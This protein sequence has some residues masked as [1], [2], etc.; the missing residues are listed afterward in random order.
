MSETSLPVRHLFSIT[1][2]TAG[3]PVIASDTPQGSRML[4][5]VDGGAAILVS[6]HGIGLVEDG[7]SKAR[8]APLFETGDERYAWLNNIQ[9]V[10]VGGPSGTSVVNEIYEL[11]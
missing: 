1:L 8:S 3:A 10:G 2:E 6:Y 11:L 4:V 9:A 5:A 7:V